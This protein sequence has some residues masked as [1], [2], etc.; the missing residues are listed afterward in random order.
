MANPVVFPRRSTP[1]RNP[2]QPHT[3]RALKPK[4]M[5]LALL[6]TVLPVAACS[7]TATPA[8]NTPAG[9]SASTAGAN[10]AGANGTGA[11][12]AGAN[13]TDSGSRQ[14]QETPPSRAAAAKV[15]PADANFAQ[16]EIVRL[17]SPWAMTFVDKDH[18]LITSKTGE[19]HA[20]DVATKKLT[21]VT[22]VPKVDVGGQG[23]LGDIITAPDF[24]TSNKVYLSW[25]ESGRLLKRGAVVGEAT[26]TREPTPKLTDVKV[27]WKQT[28]K[29][30]GRGHYSHR[31]AFSPDGKHLFVTSGDRQKL[32][33]AQ[34]TSNTLGTI[35][36]L[37]PDG[38]AA[39]GNPLSDKGSPT[40]EIW[41][42]GH[43]NPLGIAF[44]PD[45]KLWSHEMGPRGGD[46]LNL[47]V[48]GKNYGWPTVSDGVH[49]DGKP[50]PD[51]A[52]G[53]GF[54]APKTSWVPAISPSGLIIYTGDL[55]ADWQGDALL[56]GLSG[57]ALAR[58]DL[59]GISATKAERWDFGDRIREVEQHP[60][61][62]I[63]LLTDGP[64][65]TDG[66]VL[67]LTPAKK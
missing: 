49:Y 35:V 54:E 17:K 15:S 7:E 28:P 11:N 30:T 6:A 2:S 19:L 58:I 32:E 8:D 65:N 31:L 66:Q 33:P 12:S 46:E 39:S 51:H 37:A 21:P 25:V 36:R 23:G 67:R 29:T 64:K 52:P 3:V 53:D 20:L 26:Y 57:K 34:D 13:N 42:Y 1:S 27:L 45:G 50:I 18:A 41:T 9:S 61:G 40:N 4:L 5:T 56:G 38:K 43:R 47:I 62:S 44:A 60:D 24:A 48:K 63:W 22:G 14:S 16:E 10:S 55:F 59:D